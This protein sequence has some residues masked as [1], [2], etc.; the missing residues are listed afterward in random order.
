[1]QDFLHHW[2]DSDYVRLALDAATPI[3][4]LVAGWMLKR[5]EQLNAELVR[6]RIAIY[7]EIA[8]LVND[9][10]C[11]YTAVGRWR[12]LNPPA[13]I[14]QK[15]KIDRAM[16]VYRHFWDAAVW[17]RY[18]AWSE[19]CFEEYGGG[20]GRPARLRLDRAYLIRQ[21]GDG[22]R[23][24]WQPWLAEGGQPIAKARHLT[25]AWMAGF[26]RDIGVR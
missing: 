23:E 7:D 6:K 10:L 15:R 21:M 2:L 19:G 18:R 11:F 9:I 17:R 5:R 4:V 20:F 13:V 1:M 24:D 16:H 26:A 25:E 12:D 14:E 3:A 22:W 8:P